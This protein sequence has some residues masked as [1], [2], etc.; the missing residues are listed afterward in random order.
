MEGRSGLAGELRHGIL[1]V[2]DALAQSVAALWDLPH[3]KLN[4]VV[5]TLGDDAAVE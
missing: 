2:V 3:E 5:A 1:G 4:G